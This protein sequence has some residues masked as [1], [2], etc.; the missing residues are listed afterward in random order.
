[1]KYILIFALGFYFGIV[2]MCLFQINREV[3][4]E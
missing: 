4:D 3:E 1:M 2:T